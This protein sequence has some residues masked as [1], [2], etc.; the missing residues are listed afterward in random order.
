MPTFRCEAC[1]SSFE[2]EGTT[3]VCPLCKQPLEADLTIRVLCSCGTTLKAPPKMRGRVIAC[4]RCTRPVPI[5]RGDEAEEE[6]GTTQVGRKTRWIFALAL[7]PA[8]VTI[9]SE[10]DDPR[11]RVDKTLTNYKV[12]GSS[13][14]TLRQKVELIPTGRAERAAIPKDSPLPYAYGLAGLA[15]V[16]G[17]IWL[18]FATPKLGGRAMALGVLVMALSGFSLGLLVNLLLPR[19]AEDDSIARLLMAAVLGGA[20]AE[21][22]KSGWLVM[23][24]G[25]LV[26]RALLLLGLAAGAGFGAAFAIESALSMSG[27]ALGRTYWVEFITVIALQ[28]VWGGTT[29]L[30]ISRGGKSK[31]STGALIFSAAGASIGLNSVFYFLHRQEIFLGSIILGLASFALFHAL[32]FWTEETEHEVIAGETIRV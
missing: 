1:K 2:A 21:L 17:F 6:R 4:P 23:C 15:L 28:A 11:K 8:F 5:P 12:D 16:L 18:S 9:Q 10:K 26:R 3:A 25:K 20:G 31:V 29:A 14:R 22:L 7:L 27:Y 24:R 32:H 13:A 30:F 19:P